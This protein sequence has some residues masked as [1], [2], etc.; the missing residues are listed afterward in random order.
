MTHLAIYVGK[1]ERLGLETGGIS[2]SG[3]ITY[4]ARLY[5]I[6][7]D[8]TPGAFVR[9]WTSDSLEGVLFK[10]GDDQPT[11]ILRSDPEALAPKNAELL[12]LPLFEDDYK[13][14]Q[15]F[16]DQRKPKSE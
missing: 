13:F 1:D 3:S 14:L 16:L 5:R 10:L 4:V 7:D 12:A 15:K 8:K 6:G 11:T 2:F 9:E